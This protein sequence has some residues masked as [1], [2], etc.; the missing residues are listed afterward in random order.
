MPEDTPTLNHPVDS[1]EGFTPRDHLTTI[2]RRWWLLAALIFFGGLLGLLVDALRP[3]QY[4]AGF[5]ITVGINQTTAGELT[6]YEQDVMFEAVG[7]ILYAPIQLEAVAQ[8]AATRGIPLTAAALKGNSDI[9]RRL[10]TWR[11]RVRA[12]DPA[13]AEDVAR[14][15]LESS[16]V[17]LL[18]A[19]ASAREADSL[20]RYL[21]SLESCLA[22]AVTSPPSY[23]RC[24]Q[25][26]LL[27]IQEE[28]AKTGAAF[29]AARISARGMS[30]SLVF[31]LA[32]MDAAPARRVTP[33]RGQM[34]LAGGMLGF[35]AGFWL[36]QANLSNWQPKG[37][38]G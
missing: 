16:Q 1:V 10:A 20:E 3:A 4:E 32:Q 36:A 13:H 2:L 24:T 14:M 12:N 31:D 38:H 5:R 19:Y 37:H 21:S 9:E 7:G 26:E 28:I 27:A 30:S 15:W 33:Q 8:Q 25:A 23:G 22:R 17:E 6:Q 29:G 11:V 35:V 18:R 34:V